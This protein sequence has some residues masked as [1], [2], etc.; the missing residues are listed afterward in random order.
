MLIKVLM[1]IRKRL[2]VYVLIVMLIAIILGYYVNAPMIVLRIVGALSI[3][4]MLYPMLM[5]I[6]IEKVKEALKRPWFV[7]LC[8]TYAYFIASFSAYLVSHTILKPFPEIAFALAMVGAIPCSNMLI[9]WSGIAEAS[10]EDALVV[11]VTGLLLIPF[12]SPYLLALVGSSFIKFN[13]LELQAI[14]FAYILIPLILARITRRYM[15]KE[16]GKQKFMQMKKVFPSISA[17]GVLLIVFV[18][19]MKASKFVLANPL[20][21]LIIVTG[22]Y[23]YYILQTI[24]ALIAIYVLKLKY[25]LGVVLVLSAVASS[26]AISLSV[27]ATLFPPLTV[28]T[29]ATKPFLQVMYILFL[30]YYVIPWFYKRFLPEAFKRTIRT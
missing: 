18:A 26:Q 19:S 6:E 8:L 14:L 30:I 1:E 10:V 29:L 24:F 25:E 22:L 4:I 12:L 28:F 9:G 16:Y 17:L 3:F 27:A 7:A 5:G 11:A 13:P 23:S 20:V 2:Y 15:L 21:F